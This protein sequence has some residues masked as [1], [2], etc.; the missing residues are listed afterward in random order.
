LHTVVVVVV[1]VVVV[2]VGAR[3][4]ADDECVVLG[5]FR[6][7]MGL[8]SAGLCLDIAWNNYRV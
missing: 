1:V 5:P 3:E 7:N 8:C 4:G 6:D 2:A